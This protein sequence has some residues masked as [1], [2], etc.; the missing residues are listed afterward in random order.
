[1][2]ASH[3]IPIIAV[4]ATLIESEGRRSL[5]FNTILDTYEEAETKLPRDEVPAERNYWTEKSSWTLAIADALY[6]T[7]MPVLP[8]ARVNYRQQYISIAVGRNNYFRL[9]KRSDSKAMLRFR[10]APYLVRNVSDLLEDAKVYYEIKKDGYFNVIVNSSL[11][12]EA[13][14]A[15]R[16]VAALVK[17]S[18]EKEPL[19]E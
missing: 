12:T 4:Q 17:K 11:V 7:L 18:W 14:V 3:S 2:Y 10:I 16:N 15:L 6:S 1:M 5:F 13:A 8:E 19:E 9:G